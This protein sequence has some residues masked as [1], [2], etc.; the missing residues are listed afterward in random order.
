MT[1][2][3][4]IKNSMTLG[5]CGWVSDMGIIDALSNVGSNIYTHPC[6]QIKIQNNRNVNVKNK[7]C[8]DETNL[9]V[10]WYLS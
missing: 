9:H 7:K 8:L 3:L 5:F 4:G 10:H 2:L 1:M 6:I